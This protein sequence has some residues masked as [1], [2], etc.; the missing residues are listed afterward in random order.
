MNNTDKENEEGGKPTQSNGAVHAAGVTG[1]LSEERRYAEK[2]SLPF[3]L[4]PQYGN[5]SCVKA[6]IEKK[7]KTRRGSSRRAQFPGALPRC[8]ERS[9]SPRDW[10]RMW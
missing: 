1:E 5:A 6:L 8:R 2:V 7:P 9:L 3:S 4:G 10:H